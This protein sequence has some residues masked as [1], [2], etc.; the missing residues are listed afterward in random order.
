[1]SD[2]LV[3]TF[4]EDGT[5]PGLEAAIYDPDAPDLADVE[6]YQGEIVLGPEVFQD[7]SK[8]LLE[9]VVSS[10]VRILNCCSLVPP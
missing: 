3:N 6:P 1:V 4:I 10:T 2:A 8:D 7:V 9:E 5:L